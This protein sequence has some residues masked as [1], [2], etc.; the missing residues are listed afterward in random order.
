MGDVYTWV[1]HIQSRRLNLLSFSQAI[2]QLENSGTT[3]GES[4]NVPWKEYNRQQSIPTI[5]E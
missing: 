5:I 2:Q 1:I 3:L 4:K